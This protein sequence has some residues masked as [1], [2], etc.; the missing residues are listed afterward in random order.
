MYLLCNPLHRPFPAHHRSSPRL[1]SVELRLD[2]R[3]RLLAV[4]VDILLVVVCVVSV[5]AVGILSV[6]V[7]LGVVWIAGRAL[8]S[9]RAGSE[10]V[11]SVGCTPRRHLDR[12]TYALS[13]ARSNVYALALGEVRISQEDSSFNGVEGASAEG[14]AGAAA[15]GVVHDLATLRIAN[16]DDLSV[17]ATLVK[18]SHS[19]NNRLSALVRGRIVL[20]MPS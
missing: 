7:G 12:E 2:E 19:G 15:V 18:A 13:L 5:A 10:L 9:R 3:E 1:S 16:Q 8:I 17:R 6:A 4:D 14:G 20:K 11:Q